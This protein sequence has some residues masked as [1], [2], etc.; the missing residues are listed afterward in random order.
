[1]AKRIL[2]KEKIDRQLAD[3]STSTPFM[4]VRDGYNNNNTTKAVTF[5]MQDGLHDKIDKLTSMMCKLTA[6]GNKQDKHFK[7]KIYQGKK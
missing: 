2:A 4:K 5:N 1:M 7:L 6:Q 3:Q